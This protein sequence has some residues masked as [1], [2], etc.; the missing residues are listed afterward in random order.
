MRPSKTVLALAGPLLTVVVAVA[1]FFLSRHGVQ[2]YNPALLFVVVIVLAAY[3]GGHASGLASVGLTLVYVLLTWSTGFATFV[4]SESS[5]SRL[6]VFGLTMP[7]VS[8]LVSYLQSRNQRML[9]WLHAKGE[10]HTG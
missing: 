5:V 6:V 1:L 4:Y 7:M 8:L 2:V 10:R 9:E 3:L